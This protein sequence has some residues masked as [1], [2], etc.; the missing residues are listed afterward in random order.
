MIQAG[1]DQHGLQ[2]RDTPP[3]RHGAPG[4]GGRDGA[5]IAAVS[6]HTI[7]TTERILEVYVPRTYAMAKSAIVKLEQFRK[8]KN[9]Q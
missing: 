7:E 1:V 9:D 6:D 2:F 8:A 4:G 5:R 3:H